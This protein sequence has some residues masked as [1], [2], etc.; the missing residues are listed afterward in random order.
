MG[1]HPQQ[2]PIPTSQITKDVLGQTQMIYQDNR[3][4][5]MHA[6]TKYKTYY[7]KTPILQS[8]K[9]QIMYT[10]YSRKRITKLAKLFSQKF[11]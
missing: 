7:D 4:N 8:S 11:G 5:A 2:A 10:S 1:I 3:R 9:K 6:Y